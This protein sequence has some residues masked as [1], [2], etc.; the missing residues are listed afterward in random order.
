MHDA[1]MDADEARGILMECRNT[2]TQ[3][4]ERALRAVVALD[5]EKSSLIATL[6]TLTRAVR[7]MDGETDD[8]VLVS[9]SPEAIAAT[10]R[11]YGWTAITTRADR[12]ENEALAKLIRV[13]TRAEAFYVAGVE[14]T[15][16]KMAHD[17]G[18]APA[19]ILAA[20]L[21]EQA[22]IDGEGAK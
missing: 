9:V 21:R 14:R 20:M 15:V 1:P 18:E 16:R 7:A 13:P 22:R 11:A 10:L 5:E 2:T 12:F 17:H 4:E 6:D 8:A 3:F 19:F